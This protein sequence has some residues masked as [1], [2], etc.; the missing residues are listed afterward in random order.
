MH[1]I[2][3]AYTMYFNL[4]HE[5]IG[6]LFVKPF[7]SKHINKDD[8]FRQVGQYIHLNSVEL[9]EP[10]WKYGKVRHAKQLEKKLISYPYSSCGDYYGAER[11]ESAILDK[12]SFESM[13]D[14]LPPLTKVLEETQAYYQELRW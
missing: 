1:K 3:T 14:E 11:L 7:R 2:G 5:R 4:K 9:F 6:S 13:Y 8:Y 12:K 10:G